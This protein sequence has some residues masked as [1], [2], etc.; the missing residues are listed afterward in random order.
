[1]DKRVASLN[2]ISFSFNEHLLSSCSVL[3]L[4][5]TG[6]KRVTKTC[7]ILEDLIIRVGMTDKLTDK[8]NPMG[9]VWEQKYV[10]GTTEER[11]INT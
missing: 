2:H 8:Y 4:G 7:P 10:Q 6:E 9:E 5:L 1:M 11:M 3:I